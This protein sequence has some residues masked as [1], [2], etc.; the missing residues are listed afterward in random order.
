MYQFQHVEDFC[1]QNNNDDKKDFID[2]MLGCKD[3]FKLESKRME[4]TKEYFTRKVS[5]CFTDALSKAH[6]N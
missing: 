6:D 5:T 1:F 3:S 2:C 4:Y